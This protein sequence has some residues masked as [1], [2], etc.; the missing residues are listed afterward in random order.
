MTIRISDVSGSVEKFT[1]GIYDFRH[2]RKIHYEDYNVS[3]DVVISFATGENI[4]GLALCIYAGVAGSTHEQELHIGK[5]E[6]W[7]A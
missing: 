1:V 5:F 6:V 3:N 7:E 2:N 4:T